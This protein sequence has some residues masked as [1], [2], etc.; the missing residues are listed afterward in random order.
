MIGTFV[1]LDDRATDGVSDGALEGFS[2]GARNGSLD[3]SGVGETEGSFVGAS[4]VGP[5]TGALVGFAEAVS[6]QKYPAYPLLISVLNVPDV[7]SDVDISE[8]DSQLVITGTL[9]CFL[10]VVS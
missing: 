7:S 2:V 10:T 4:V 3:G 5:T 1:G 6:D 8:I 9:L